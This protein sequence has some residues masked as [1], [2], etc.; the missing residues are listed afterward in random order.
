MEGMRE[1]SKENID[2][3]PE[4]PIKLDFN[5]SKK[6]AKASVNEK[7]SIKVQLKDRYNNTVFNDNSTKLK[8]EIPS[9]YTN[10]LKI[11]S[12]FEKISIK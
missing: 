1:I 4:K 3:E 6:I 9:E 2:I 5:I 10:I 12:S 7:I 11:D 8:I